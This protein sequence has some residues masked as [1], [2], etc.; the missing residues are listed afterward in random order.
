MAQSAVVSVAGMGA[1]LVCL[2]A[3][4]VD[5]IEILLHELQAEGLIP[6][7][8][9]DIK[10]DLPPDRIGQLEGR[11][12]GLELGNERLP[13]AVLLVVLLERVALLLAAV[14]SCAGPMTVRMIFWGWGSARR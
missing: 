9:E 13:H 10:A 4:E 14:P 3:E 7:L 8:W 2:I 5:L 12:L 11:E 6:T 1:H